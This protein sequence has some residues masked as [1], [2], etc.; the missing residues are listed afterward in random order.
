M[1]ST[2]QKVVAVASVAKYQLLVVFHFDSLLFPR[3]IIIIIIL[4][5]K[6]ER[7]RTDR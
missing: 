3:I 5:E 1:Q 7:T 4:T 6:P 2:Y